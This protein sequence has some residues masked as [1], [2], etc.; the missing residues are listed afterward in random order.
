MGSGAGE[1]GRGLE[2]HQLPLI[3]ER[4]VAADFSVARI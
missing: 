4:N 2:R 3:E 1:D